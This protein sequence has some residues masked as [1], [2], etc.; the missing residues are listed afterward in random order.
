[1]HLV[2]FISLLK[3]DSLLFFLSCLLYL[4]L[5]VLIVYWNFN[6]P[7]QMQ[8]VCGCL[9]INLFVGLPLIFNFPLQ[10]Y[11]DVLSSEDLLLIV[12]TLFPT[13]KR[14]MLQRMITFNTKV[15]Y[16]LPLITQLRRGF[17]FLVGWVWI[18]FLSFKGGKTS[19]R[20]VWKY[21]VGI[22]P[23]RLTEVVWTHI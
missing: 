22:Q 21:T 19:K 13:F 8:P 16:E 3:E 17:H 23:E 18:I 7:L 6:L 11:V 14:N 10:V 15:W 20:R 2:N 4:T 12:S 9:L 5:W 1:M